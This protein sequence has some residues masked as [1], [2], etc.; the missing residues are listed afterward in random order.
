MIYRTNVC[1]FCSHTNNSKNAS[2][3][4]T[5]TNEDP[6]SLG[7][8]F[9]DTRKAAIEKL[10]Q[11]TDTHPYPHKFQISCTVSDYIQKYEHLKPSETLENV[12]EEVA[13]RILSIRKAGSKLFFFDI[14]SD[15]AK[16]QVKVNQ[17]NYDSKEHFTAELSK[18]HRGDII[19]IKGSP[20]RTKSGELS[21]N[22]KTVPLQSN[23]NIHFSSKD[24]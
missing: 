24:F 17:S 13:G 8:V 14:Q 12:T 5:K 23:S 6:I 18:Y 7:K 22:S 21:I 19:G 2:K 4:K 1:Q 20:V 11:N 15:G 10:K 16:L 9:F 3:T